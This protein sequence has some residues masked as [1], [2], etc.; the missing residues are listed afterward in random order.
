MIITICLLYRANIQSAGEDMTLIQWRFNMRAK[1]SS[2]HAWNRTAFLWFSRQNVGGMVGES[3][4]NMCTES[5]K[6]FQ[7]FFTLG[8]AR[9]RVYLKQEQSENALEE[10]KAAVNLCQ[11]CQ[12]W[13]GCSLQSWEER[14]FIIICRQSAEKSIFFQHFY[15][16]CP[17]QFWPY[18]KAFPPHIQDYSFLE[19]CLGQLLL[20]DLFT[21]IAGISSSVL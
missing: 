14:V 10:M 18:S 17:G 8:E 7:V 9:S 13:G 12:D 15:F 6:L 21:F 19:A 2:V 20:K 5:L 11:R 16:W 3:E 1:N 4:F